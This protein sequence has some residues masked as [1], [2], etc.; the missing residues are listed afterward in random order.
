MHT[1]STTRQNRRPL[2]LVAAGLS[3][4]LVAAGVIGSIASAA[5]AADVNLSQGKTATASSVE[6]ADYTPAKA[7]V[8]GDNGTRW[9]SQ[10]TDAQWL[11]V[12]LGSSKTIG[13]V[14]LRWETAYAKAFTIQTSQ[15]GTS[16]TTVATVTNGTGGNQTVAAPGTGR[17]VR[18]NLT[19]RATGYGYSLW[20]FQ[21][22]GPDGTTPTATPT[23]T[24][25]T[26][27]CGTTNAALG[28]ASSASS[29]QTGSDS[30]AHAAAVTARSSARRGRR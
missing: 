26:G 25:P 9:S 17:Y 12:D 6:S 13:S 7:A 11:Q 10:S 28:K 29:V 14:Q 15:D 18:I 5:S 8:D 24:T 20:E 22:F 23:P 2:A 16:W 1:H 3:A 19:Q 30:A 21:V 27:T 4:A